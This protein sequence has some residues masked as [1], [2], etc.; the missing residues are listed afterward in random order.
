MRHATIVKKSLLDFYYLARVFLMHKRN[1][2]PLRAQ[3]QN[4]LILSYLSIH[5]REN[6]EESNLKEMVVK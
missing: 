5:C 6:L 3:D 2:L 1:F 4:S